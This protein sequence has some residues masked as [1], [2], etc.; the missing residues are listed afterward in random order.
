MIQYIR[1]FFQM[2]GKLFLPFFIAVIILSFIGLFTIGTVRQLSNDYD[3]ISRSYIINGKLEEV[4]AK[5]VLGQTELRAFYVTGDT[6]YLRGYRT[7]IDTIQYLMHALEKMLSD[8]QQKNA[9]QSLQSILKE[10]ERFNEAKIQTFVKEGNAT[11]QR[12]YP[13][14]RNQQLIHLMDSSVH[15]MERW[16]EEVLSERYRQMERRTI[17]TFLLISFGG[18]GSIIV[19]V[20]VFV[21]LNTE[22]RQRIKAEKEIRES[23]RRLFNFMEAVPAGIYILTADG[24][25]F[26]ANEMAK[27]ILGQ[28]ILPDTTARNLTEVYHAY[29][30]GTDSVYPPE[31]TPIVRALYGERSAVSDIEIWRPDAVAP[32]FITGAPIYDSEGT[33]RYAMSAFVDITQQKIAE[34][35][36]AES[37]E[38]FRQIIEYATDIIYRTDRNGNFTYINPV[39][40]TMFGYTEQE[41]LGMSYLTVTYEKE[42]EHV[43]RFY[44]RQAASRTPHTYLEFSAVTKDGRR[45]ILG[46]NVQLL[47]SDNR[48][49]GFLVVARDITEKKQAEETLRQAKEAAESATVAKS[50]FLAT[51]SHEIRTPMNGVIGMTDLLMQTELTPEQREY[52][53]TIRNSGETLLT[54]I[55]DILDFSKIESG[56]LELEN[57]PIDLQQLIEDTL[58]LVAHRAMEKN[59]D[60]LY[61]IDQSVPSYIVGDPVRLKQILLN[62]TN[63]AVKFTPQGEVFISVRELSRKN[64]HTELEF[65]VKDT[66][67]G[68]PKEKIDTLFQAFT[69]VDASTTRRFGGTGLG[70]AITKRLV[71]M[72][73]GKVWIESDA[74]K[75]ATVFFTV[76]VGTA[77]SS[78]L[79]PKKYV[80]GNIPELQGKRVLVVDDNQTNLNILSIQCSVWGM[81]PRVT[82]SQ[83]EALQWLSANDPFDL[84]ILDFHMPEMNGVEFA[85]EIRKMRESL[86]LILF[87]SSG[88]SEFNNAD[89]ALFAAV[90]LKPIKHSQFYPTLLEVLSG[91]GKKIPTKPQ[92]Q[93]TAVRSI[94]DEFPLSI[95]IAE[96]NPVNQKLAVRLLKQLGYTADV[97][98]NG[99][100]VLSQIRKRQYDIILM[101]L[102]MPEMDGLETT[103]EIVH[104]VDA[105]IRP[106]IIAMTADAMSGDREKCIDAGMDDYLSKPVRLEGLRAMLRAYGDVIVRNKVTTP[107]PSSDEEYMRTRLTEL[108]K[109]TDQ[110]FFREIVETF[111]PHVQEIAA[112]LQSAWK[113]QKTNEAIFAAHKLRGVALNF[114][115]VSLAE[116]SKKIEQA[117]EA[118]N[119]T[120]DPSLLD[121]LQAEVQRSL[122]LLSNV[123]SSIKA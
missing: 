11:A 86:P 120:F 68:I 31:Q 22:I 34:Q 70:L 90:V 64:S 35:K 67:I 61:L 50:L 71:E 80:K 69:Q 36:L 8:Q 102:H 118:K 38:R 29:R 105:Q 98:S 46:Q 111:P 37:E 116:I 113:E 95:L 73:N 58:D 84:A 112:E 60:L 81:H 10:R 115:A 4:L 14:Q 93:Q 57:R 48:V 89:N 97:V 15:V 100:E 99:K 74:G 114:G 33:L 59:L 19:L 63:N 52:T 72:M 42:R 94:A 26:Y 9:L 45:I 110:E 51:M 104:T 101:D 6:I 96:D 56:K 87:S 18:I 122:A 23:E 39:G 27:Q 24:T 13:T 25:P 28:G 12:K 32:L 5:S 53:E 7:G 21:F 43:R 83:R 79:P 103:R 91:S 44:L 41:A 66:G 109:E 82:T 75:G 3:L 2:K 17:L 117:G 92:P 123:V 78:D 47:M 1:T 77:E 65:A 16:E 106:K 76:L 85:R 30:S 55:N 40:L 119:V 54:L 20:I 108:L 62:V 49:Q 107:L 88:R 121:A